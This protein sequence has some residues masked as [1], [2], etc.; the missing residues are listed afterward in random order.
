M[1]PLGLARLGLGLILLGRG[2]VQGDHQRQSPS[3]RGPGDFDQHGQDDPLVPPA[4]GGEGMSGTDRVAMTTL[5]VDLGTRVLGDR[6]V[7]RQFDRALGYEPGQHPVDVP[8]C[9]DQRAPAVSGEDAVKTTGVAGSQSVQA[10]EQVGDGSSAE[11][12]DGGQRQQDEPGVGGAREGRFEGIEDRAG[13]LGEL[14][15]DPLELASAQAGLLGPLASEG[16]ALFSGE[17]LL[18]SSADAWLVGVLAMVSPAHVPAL[19]G[20]Q[21]LVRPSGYTGHGS[22]LVCDVRAGPYPPLHQGGSPLRNPQKTAE[23]ELRESDRTPRSAPENRID[24]G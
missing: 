2:Q 16:P 10:P 3:P 20:R 8:P 18:L 22:L 21:A 9:Q 5:A 14:T 1:R 13:W 7:A 17:P 11:D 19:V 15:A 6:V 23:V 24:T 12:Q 4:K